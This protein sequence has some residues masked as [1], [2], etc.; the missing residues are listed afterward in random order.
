MLMR[1]DIHRSYIFGVGQSV[2]V[3]AGRGGLLLLSSGSSS[4]G[5]KCRVNSKH[6]RGVSGGVGV[7]VVCSVVSTTFV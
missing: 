3:G 4:R 2:L 7:S 6:S 1:S 5:S